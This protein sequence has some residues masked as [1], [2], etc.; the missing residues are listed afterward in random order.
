[1]K[2]GGI[3]THAR[4][5]ERHEARYEARIEPHPDHADQ[6]RLTLPD[7]LLGL[8]VVD[9]SEGGLGLLS[10][11]YLPRNMRLMLHISN[12]TACG[13][14][15]PRDLTIR[16]VVRR[17]VMVDHKPTYRAGLQFVDQS[18]RDECLLIG[19]A[20]AESAGGAQA[21]RAGGAGVT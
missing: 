17:C 2:N 10:S 4:Q 14:A 13:D 12:V 7:A 3:P 15:A 6:F 20:M 19:S 8:A 9:V 18:G 11:T 1:M 16:A 21:V 5:F